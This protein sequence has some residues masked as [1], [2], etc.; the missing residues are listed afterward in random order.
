MVLGLPEKSGPTPIPLA[1]Y[2][3]GHL[4]QTPIKIL[5]ISILFSEVN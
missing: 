1:K 2:P 3:V 4:V 5:E